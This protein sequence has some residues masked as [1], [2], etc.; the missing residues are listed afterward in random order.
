M[1]IIV[2]GSLGNISRPLAQ[3]LVQKGHTVTVV[4]SR[5]D[6]KQEIEALGAKPAIGSFAM[7]HHI[8]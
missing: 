8:G 1:K 6:R 4:S 7:G 5:A 3:E 2:T